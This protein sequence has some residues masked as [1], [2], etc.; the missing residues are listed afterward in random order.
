MCKQERKFYDTGYIFGDEELKLENT[1]AIRLLKH[2]QYLQD[3][4]GR[5]ITLNY[6]RTKENKEVDFVIVENDQATQLIEVKL[7]DSNISS[8]LLYLKRKFFNVNATQIV[9][10][11]R[12]EQFQRGINIK[13]QENG[14]PGFPREF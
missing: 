9:H 6:I 5:N 1:C 8:S 12:Q 10:N 13:K 3:Y 14:Q 11:L 4:E 7:S 2:I